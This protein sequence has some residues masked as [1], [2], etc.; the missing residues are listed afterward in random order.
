[1]TENPDLDKTYQVGELTFG[2]AHCVEEAHAQAGQSGANA[3]RPG[4]RVAV[5]APGL[6]A[7]PTGQQ[8]ERDLKVAGVDAATH[9]VEGTSRQTVTVVPRRGETCPELEKQGPELSPGSLSAGQFRPRRW[10]ISSPGGSTTR[11]RSRGSRAATRPSPRPSAA[12]CERIPPQ[13]CNKQMSKL[14]VETS[15]HPRKGNDEQ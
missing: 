13:P 15:T 14:N 6:A 10:A 8:I 2:V 12:P 4:A 11:R 9:H 3:A 7:G 5:P 1:M